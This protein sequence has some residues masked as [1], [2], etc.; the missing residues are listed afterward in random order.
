LSLAKLPYPLISL[1]FIKEQIMK[2]F[3]HSK[4]LVSKNIFHLSSVALFIQ[5]V[6]ILP[7]I[8]IAEKYTTPIRFYSDEEEIYEESYIKVE[9]PTNVGINP[10]WNIRQNP[11]NKKLK[12]ITTS[13]DITVN[14]TYGIRAVTDKEPRD[15]TPELSLSSYK[16]IIFNNSY[17]NIEVPGNNVSISLD[18]NNGEINF[19]LNVADNTKER[20]M[21]EYT[22]G[23]GKKSG[24]IK[25]TSKLGNT[26]S[27]KANLG[28]EDMYGVNTLNNVNTELDS[29]EG[30]NK[31]T[32]NITAQDNAKGNLIGIGTLINSTTKLNGQNN[33]IGLTVTGKSYSGTSI[34]IRAAKESNVELTATESNKIEGSKIGID[35]SNSS[36]VTLKGKHNLISSLDTAIKAK[37]IGKISVNGKLEIAAPLASYVLN[38]GDISL[39]YSDDSKINGA[40]LA[41]DGNILV[42]STGSTLNMTGDVLVLNQGKVEL[43]LMSNSNLLGRIDN[44]NAFK[45]AKHS[46]LFNTPV[47]VTRNNSGTVNLN[48]AE[49]AVWKMTE[50][51]W[52]SQLSGDGSIDFN[53]QT[54]DQGRALHIDTLSG[55]NRFLMNLN[56]DG[57]H[58]DMLYI[59]KGTSIAQELVI[60]NL[61]EVID[62][63]KYGDRLRFATVKDSK[64]EF[65]AGKK[66]VDG[67]HLMEEAL[68]VEYSDENNDPSNKTQY[69]KDFNGIEMTT[70]KPGDDY[71]HRTYSGGKNVYLV[72]GR[73]DTPV[74]NVK[75]ISDMFDSTGHYALDLD[76]Y[77]KR[78]GERTYSWLTKDDGAWVRMAHS[79]LTQSGVFRFNNN[80]YEIGYDKL[81]RNDA[82]KKRKW[83][84]SFTY[85][86]A[87]ISLGNQFSNGRIKKYE[88]SLYNT[89]Q[90]QNLD[91]D[92]SDYFDNVL[93][94]GLLH[95]YTYARMNN[96]Q[97]WGKGSYKNKI[98]TASTEYGYHKFIDN[99]KRWNITPQAQLQFTYLS[100]ANYQLSNKVNVNLSDSKSLVGRVGMDI[101][102]WLDKDG[103]HRFYAK[104]NILHEF[105][106][107]HGFKA[108]DSNDTY[109]K[110]WNTKATWYVIGLGYTA[111][112]SEKTYIFID[113]ERELGAG[114][115]NSY[116]ARLAISWQFK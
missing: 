53:R 24:K 37:E 90:R 102:R 107:K 42:K 41:D 96:G 82:E 65:V 57:I 40:L 11:D 92:N 44:F 67:S 49:K 97:L 108:S 26:L 86:R 72:K 99:D 25:L 85:G 6:L 62:S 12:L 30:D 9:R 89:N 56:K 77:T 32:L 105:L 54:I 66:Y 110:N 103:G 29:K 43:N 70:E 114:R 71:I 13:G 39:N 74:N 17:N 31:I 52:L 1:Y 115:A 69:N 34:G 76:T 23:D 91:G 58:S 80:N 8:A 87:R 94:I 61:S 27:L 81:S 48:L 4:T 112:V 33:L 106:G 68:T 55:S 98:I 18:A 60:N 35:S 75:D 95:N 7:N 59:K 46:I 16:D 38:K 88:L 104:A 22:A 15:F 79:K 113:A 10:T 14:A 51:S 47:S 45:E 2:K 63:M 64:N 28:N 84:L 21:I 36:N 100:G 101:V 3:N 109:S 5:T 83:G 93:R 111:H 73:T 50:Q 19:N 20:S 116:N 78:E